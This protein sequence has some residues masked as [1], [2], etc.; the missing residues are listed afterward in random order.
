M[1]QVSDRSANLFTKTFAYKTRKDGQALNCQTESANFC[2]QLTFAYDAN[3][4]AEH[5]LDGDKF[6]DDRKRVSLANQRVLDVL[7]KRN[8]SELR[9]ALRRALYSETHALF[10]VR[11]SC[12]GQE[13]WSSACQLG[14]SFLCFATEGL[15]NA[16]IEMAEGVQKKKISNA[17]KRYLALTHTEPRRCAKFVYNLG[18]KV[19]LQS[20][21]SHNVQNASSI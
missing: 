18:K 2:N 6:K 8:E 4:M 13:R 9:D 20:L 11:V 14:A 19:L 3:T 21:L 5:N 16:I 1:E 12:K 7:K 15:V 17:Y 10:N